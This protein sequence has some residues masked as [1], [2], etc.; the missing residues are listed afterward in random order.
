M[1]GSG[2]TRHSGR[3]RYVSPASFLVTII[4]FTFMF[5]PVALP[6]TEKT[7]YNFRLINNA[8]PSPTA[9]L[10]PDSAGN[11]Y[12]TTASGGKYAQGSVYKIAANGKVSILY[13]FKNSPD[14]AFPEGKLLRDGKGNFY[15]TTNGGGATGYGT[16]FELSSSGRETVLH[17]FS[18]PTADGW[19]PQGGLLMDKNGNLFGTTGSGGTNNTGTVFE[20]TPD[21]VETILYNFGPYTSSASFPSPDLIRDSKGIFYGTTY[22]T[23]NCGTVFSLTPG[24]VLTILHTSP[25]MERTDVTRPTECFVT[26]TAIFTVRPKRVALTTTEPSS[27][28]PVKVPSRFFS[29]FPDP[30]AQLRSRDLRETQ[31]ATS[32]GQP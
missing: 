17:S 31:K 12:G 23:L 29:R 18:Y 6:Q 4:V 25:M 16:V 11:L 24:G 32:T 21:G 10:I 14:G 7:L 8:D 3:T 30:T 27:K 13:S 2:S 22:S 28:S 5:C 20:I 15:G 1:S 19:G 9:A 26:P